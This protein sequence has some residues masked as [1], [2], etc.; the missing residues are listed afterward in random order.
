MLVPGPPGR[1]LKR[2]TSA[3]HVIGVYDGGFR[4]FCGVYHPAGEC[5]MRQ[6]T[7]SGGNPTVYPFCWVC[8]YFLI[9]RLDPTKH[10][11]VERTFAG[12]YPRI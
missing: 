9:D 11:V 7:S 5:L 6:L 12:R 8:A 1:R 4:Y 3:Q 2:P 10:A